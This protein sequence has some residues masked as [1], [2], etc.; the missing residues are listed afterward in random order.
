MA[1]QELHLIVITPARAV[2]DDDARSVVVPAFDGELGVMANHAALI[3]LLGNGPLRITRADGSREL[4]AVRGGFL[5][6][7]NNVVT[8]LTQESVMADEI[9]SKQV[10]ADLEEAR[11]LPAVTDEEFEVRESKLAWAL[12]RRK[13]LEAARGE[14]RN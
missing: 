9:D 2:Y 3:S 5:Q 7:K 4:L 13:I 14:S 11:A 8:V 12:T 1:E 10:D 6:V